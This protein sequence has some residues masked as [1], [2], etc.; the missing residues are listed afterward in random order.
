MRR[1]VL[2]PVEAIR[3][4]RSIGNIVL[5]QNIITSNNS[6]RGIGYGSEA[7]RIEQNGK[8]EF[9]RIRKNNNSFGVFQDWQRQ[10]WG[11]AES[12]TPKPTSQPPSSG[13]AGLPLGNLTAAQIDA[14]ISNW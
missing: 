10:G 1:N 7:D 14:A 4:S 9:E 5:P 6:Y 13:S 12:K 2:S 11:G 8:L 3:Y